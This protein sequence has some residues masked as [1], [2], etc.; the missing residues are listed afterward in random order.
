MNRWVLVLLSVAASSMIYQFSVISALVFILG[1]GQ[2][3]FSMFT[4]TFLCSMGFG[5]YWVSDQGNIE[6][7]FIRSQLTLAVAGFAVLP[8][9]FWL[10]SL[11]MKHHL[12][13]GVQSSALMTGVMWPLGL[14]AEVF[15]GVLVGMQLPLLQRIIKERL[16][17]DMSL[18]VILALDYV[19]SFIGAVAFPLLLFP[20]LGLFRTAFLAALLNT[21]TVSVSVW[22]SGNSQKKTGYFIFLSVLAGVILFSFSETTKLESLFDLIIYG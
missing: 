16:G 1:D 6:K 18:S 8:L 20:V 15:F 7:Y 13:D 19:G 17:Q 4:G 9:I 10:Y 21:V 12:Q 2:L 3:L 5:A 11:L 22:D 14:V